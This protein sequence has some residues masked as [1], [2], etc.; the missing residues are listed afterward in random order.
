[1]TKTIPDNL[2]VLEMANNHMG[3]IAHGLE[4]IRKFGAVCQ[5]FPEFNFAFKLQYRD[6][7]TF[8]HPSMQGRDDIKYIKRFSETRLTREEFDQLVS[9]MRNNGFLTM[10]T[11]F[12]EA[13][14]SIIEEQKLD[15][16]KIASCS[17][18]DWP[19][20]ERVVET[21]MP[22]IASTAGASLEDIDRVVS[23]YEHREKSF[24]ILHCVGE[25]PTADDKM[26]ISQISFL[27]DRYPGVRIG[28]S[29]HESPDNVDI[30]KLAIAKG[31][32]V[33]EKHVGVPTDA[34]SLNA[35]SANPKQVT[36]WLDAARYANRVCGVG[37]ARSPSNPVEQS[38]L[39]SLQR[40]IFMRRNI[41]AGEVVNRED[42]YFAFP[43]EKG[44]YSATEW[45]KYATFTTRLPILKDAPL[46]VEN[47]RRD[48]VQSKVLAAA[49]Q[50]KALLIESS[51][52]VPGGLDLELSHHYGIDKFNEVG[53][54][55]ITVVNRGYC[56]KLLVS[57]PNQYHPEQYHNEKEETFH[58]LY[59]EVNVTLNG[60]MNTYYP[61]DVI[62]IE[63]KARHAF[64]SKTGAVIE[65]L[66][67]TH[68]KNDSFYTDSSIN[69]NL[70]RKTFLRY[71]M[72]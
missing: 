23:F 47:S 61:G 4:I 28:F 34:F 46:L 12:D 30:V 60:V 21:E 3:D 52:N 22:I 13:S 8:I 35:Y 25:Y 11:P 2:F 36:A 27:A 62:N 64:V 10:A 6:L 55:M 71:W 41:Q 20:L 58:I 43:P 45:S 15:I 50:V 66:S 38:S 19:L 53:L 32:R 54:T 49:Q 42:V 63:P 37:D 56:K 18:R 33:F 14:V 1:M 40:G 59:G 69:K 65:E 57:L 31:A 16:I 7:D 72:K 24:A 44:Q 17:C 51:I 29:T 68:F 39:R 26:H 70:N 67:S 9:E 5:K 48:D